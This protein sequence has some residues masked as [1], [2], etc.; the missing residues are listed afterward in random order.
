MNLSPV[1]N[2]STYELQRLENIKRNQRVLRDLA[3]E[4]LV[5]NIQPK[6]IEKKRKREPR[7]PTAPTRRSSRQRGPAPSLFQDEQAAD[8]EREVRAHAISHATLVGV[9]CLELSILRL[10]A[11][12]L[13]TPGHLQH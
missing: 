8:V 9:A 3:I 6:R 7:P 1:G 4:P 2:L 12:E 5:S 13:T 10:D 11:S